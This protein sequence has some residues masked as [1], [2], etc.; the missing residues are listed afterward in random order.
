MKPFNPNP[1]Q[2]DQI[3]MY[4]VLGLIVTLAVYFGST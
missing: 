1:V 3:A 2:W 4:A